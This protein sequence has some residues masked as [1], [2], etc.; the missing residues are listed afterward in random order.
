MRATNTKSEIRHI[1]G[2]LQI[3]FDALYE[4]GVIDPVLKLDWSQ[5]I[6][7]IDANA[8]AIRRAVDIV[9]ACGSD[10]GRLF[11][12]LQR[13][14]AKTLELLA[15]EVAREYAGFHSRAVVH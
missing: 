9:N 6:E 7:E 3:V 4:L 15:V 5:H 12:E 11:M 2:D 14:D 13:L 1:Q 8:F 10:R